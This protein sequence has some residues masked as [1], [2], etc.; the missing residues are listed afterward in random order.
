MQTVAFG[1]DGQWDPAVWPWE[2]CLITSDESIHVCV[3]GS[4]CCTVE[5][6]TL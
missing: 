4:T 5:N 6:R 1:M 3:T 2:Q